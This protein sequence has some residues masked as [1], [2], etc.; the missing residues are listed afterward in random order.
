MIGNK[1]RHVVDDA[2]VSH[3][4]GRP[5]VTIVG[6]DLVGRVDGH[7]V[8]VV[9][10]DGVL[11]VLLADI[12][13][14]EMGVGVSRGGGVVVT[15]G[16]RRDDVSQANRRTAEKKSNPGHVLGAIG[17]VRQSGSHRRGSSVEA[18]HASYPCALRSRPC[19]PRQ[20]GPF[21]CS[22]R[23]TAGLPLNSPP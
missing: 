5:I 8:H 11:K 18:R 15:A 9:G 23:R 3:P 7:A 17:F 21:P 4:D 12:V 2:P 13:G 19:R 10:I 22:Q 1:V 20:D 6:R 16:R 14:C